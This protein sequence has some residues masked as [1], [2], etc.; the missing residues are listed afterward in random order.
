MELSE[1]WERPQRVEGG[2]KVASKMGEASVA[3]RQSSTGEFPGLVLTIYLEVEGI[4]FM[5]A[6]ARLAF[7]KLLLFLLWEE[8]AV[9]NSSLSQI[10]DHG[11]S[12]H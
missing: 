5:L 7:W 3:R 11:L 2:V 9:E 1:A 6:G 10:H 4:L 8:C 12:A